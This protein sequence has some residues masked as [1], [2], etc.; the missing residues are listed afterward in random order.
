MYATHY[1]CYLSCVYVTCDIVFETL[2]SCFCYVE[3]RSCCCALC[4][5]TL[6]YSGMAYLETQHYIR[7]D[8]ATRNVLVAEGNIVCM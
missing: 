4:Y 5:S 2:V 7:C 6:C 8:L 1:H 3:Q